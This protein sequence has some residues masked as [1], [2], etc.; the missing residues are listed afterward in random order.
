LKT[1][2]TDPGIVVVGSHDLSS[3]HNVLSNEFSRDR[4]KILTY[5]RMARSLHADFA[6]DEIVNEAIGPY[7]SG[8]RVEL[9]LS[10]IDLSPEIKSRIMGEFE[11][12]LSL[13]HAQRT[14]QEDFRQWYIDG[15]AAWIPIPHDKISDGIREVRKIDSRFITK[16][17]KIGADSANQANFIDCYQTEEAFAFF[18]PTEQDYRGQFSWTNRYVNPS[19]QVVELDR[20]MVAYQDSGLQDEYGNTISYLDTAGK[21]LNMLTMQEDS[22][23]IYRLVRA[24][25]RRAWYVDVGGISKGKAEEYIKSLIDKQR[26][27]IAYNSMTGAM[28]SSVDVRSVLDDLYLPVRSDGRG[29]KVETLPGGSN[30]GE[31]TD[32]VYL[33]ENLYRA[34]K[35]PVSRVKSEGSFSLGRS[36]EITRDEVKF[37]NF[38]QGLVSKHSNLF[39]D[40]L[41]VQL[42]LTKVMDLVE[43]ESFKD[44]VYITYSGNS[45]FAEMKELD[46]LSERLNVA[47]RLL[48]YV[49]AGYIKNAHINKILNLE[50]QTSD[51]IKD[52]DDVETFEAPALKSQYK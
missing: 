50:V 5:R 52:E 24:P 6:I 14:L 4:E 20:K 40:L 8:S 48:P 13:T 28:T 26:S 38:I 33:K 12:V 21:P 9:D 47:D 22:M 42:V 35:I 36:A 30:L 46:I 49:E 31:I 25:E 10:Q 7:Q 2:S 23:V 16:I 32:I 44:K 18:P 17:T 27:R 51:S 45:F 37:Y 43:W 15:K 19:T 39:R 1:P 34:L 29:T 41:G 3:Y 11:K